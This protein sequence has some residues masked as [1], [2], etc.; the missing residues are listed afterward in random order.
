MT[1]WELVRD[2][3]RRVVGYLLQHCPDE[4]DFLLAL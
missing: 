2:M 4:I 3:I 1:I